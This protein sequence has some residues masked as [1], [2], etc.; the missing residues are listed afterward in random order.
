MMRLQLL[1]KIDCVEG[2]TYICTVRID[3]KGKTWTERYNVTQQC[4]LWRT[5][6]GCIHYLVKHKTTK[7]EPDTTGGG[8]CAG[9]GK[10]NSD[11]GMPILDCVF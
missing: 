3:R 1:V 11:E 7:I 4:M 10:N 8:V 5:G 9:Y 2:F 6:I